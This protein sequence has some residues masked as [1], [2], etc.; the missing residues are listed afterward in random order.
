MYVNIAIT[1]SR[2]FCV[3]LTESYFTLALEQIKNYVWTKK[4]IPFMKFAL[5]RENLSLGFATM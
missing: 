2:K 5:S 3:F 1:T 4:T